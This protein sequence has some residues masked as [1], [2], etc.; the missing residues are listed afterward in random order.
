MNNCM[1]VWTEGYQI[2]H[3][4]ELVLY[5]DFAEEVDVVYMNEALSNG[6]VGFSE[7]KFAGCRYRTVMTDA[8]A[9]GLRAAFIWLGLH[10]GHWTGHQDMSTKVCFVTQYGLKE[11]QIVLV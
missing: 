7:I 11:W 9:S 3:G 4:I 2:R 5:A 10:P 1:A 6:A 8:G